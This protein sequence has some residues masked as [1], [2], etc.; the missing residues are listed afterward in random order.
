MNFFCKFFADNSFWSK[1]A[2]SRHRRP[3]S[4]RSSESGITLFCLPTAHSS[5]IS[6]TPHPRKSCRNYF[7]RN[8]IRSWDRYNF[9]C[10]SP[11][12]KTRVSDT[13]SLSYHISSSHFL[14]SQ[15]LIVCL[16]YGYRCHKYQI[17]KMPIKNTL[18]SFGSLYY[19]LECRKFFIHGQEPR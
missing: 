9:F 7:Y 14:L 18:K 10:F 17:K 13:E 6:N 5:S 1:T 12:A 8:R 16:Q 11:T 2:R 3:H 4:L 19:V 15:F